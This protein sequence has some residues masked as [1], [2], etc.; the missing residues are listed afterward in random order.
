MLG[1]GVC[2]GMG[3]ANTMHLACEALGMAL[4]G[5]HPGPGQQPADVAT[6]CEQRRRA[7]SSRM[8]GED[9]RP[10]DIL[11]TDAFANAVKVDRWRSAARS[12]R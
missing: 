1:P 12:T 7:A 6:R 11:T 8:V 5:T 10:R 3:T 9:L 2:A 4:P